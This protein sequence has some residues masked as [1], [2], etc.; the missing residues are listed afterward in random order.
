MSNDLV[1]GSDSILV[2]GAF[3]G[4]AARSWLFLLVFLC[5][6]P[7]NAQSIYMVTAPPSDGST[8]GLVGPNGMIEHAYHRTAVLVDGASLRL[9]PSGTA[10]TRFGFILSKGAGARVSGNLTVYFSDT[11]TTARDYNMVWSEIVAGMTRAYS[12]PFT[13]PDTAGPVDVTLSIPFRYGGRS[14][15]VAYQFE[16]SGPFTTKNAVFASNIALN[17]TAR[18]GFSP[19]APPEVMTELSDFRPVLRLG[20][21][22]PLMKWVATSAGTV[23]NLK[24]IDVASDMVA[25][26]CTPAGGIRRSTDRGQ[27]WLMAGSVPDSTATISGFTQDIAVAIVQ[28][29]SRAGSVY[30]TSNGGLEW[31]R[32]YDADPRMRIAQIGKTS[33]DIWCL[34]E[35]AD[36]SVIL[37][38]SQDRGSTW[39]KSFA[40]VVIPHGV[41]ITSSCPVGTVVWLGVGDRVY[42]VENDLM[43]PWKVSS[44]GRPNVS[45][46]A[47]GSSNGTGFAGHLGC[48]DT[49]YRSLDGGLTWAAIAVAGLGEIVSLQY[50][51]GGQDAWAATSTGIWRTSDFGSTWQ[52][53]FSTDGSS[54][55]LS[56]VCFFPNFQSALAIG[57]NGVI[58][59]GS[60]LPNLFVGVSET[61]IQPKGYRLGVNYPNPFNGRTWI[62]F[63]LPGPAFVSLSLFDV[64]GRA[65][66]TLVSGERGAGSHKVEWNSA[67]NPSGVY[68]YRLH[69]R[70]M[71]GGNS[72]DYLETR[73]LILL[74]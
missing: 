51:P 9:L 33:R 47:F 60:W 69:A 64:L 10:I 48:R 37:L 58:V 14:M 57:S 26:I 49:V 41:H 68:F 2:R 39:T 1:T 20:F 8:T 71:S 70:A 23:D 44:T 11:P 17:S 34:C 67:G 21:P 38:T 13:I 15:Y 50:F 52:R 36:D 73:K 65:V 16:S 30:R 56:S 18:S 59:Q 55:A 5:C 12:G 53:S 66:A 31:S 42:R 61:S 29:D 45:C 19:T 27:S 40:G 3:I 6:S 35:S 74:K 32:V 24:A 25:W 4:G 54:I 63:S 43:G 22:I 28:R 46:L 7:V 62:E 72:N